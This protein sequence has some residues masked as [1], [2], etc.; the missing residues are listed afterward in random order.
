M[1]TRS[2]TINRH[3]K[4]TEIPSNEFCREGISFSFYFPELKN[5]IISRKPMHES[6]EACNEGI[7][8]VRW[9]A[10]WYSGLSCLMSCFSINTSI[11][12]TPRAMVI[13]MSSTSR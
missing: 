3:I 5:L 11:N 9:C 7:P 6:C 13:A 12:S 4:Y 8:F 2:G 1:R 10:R